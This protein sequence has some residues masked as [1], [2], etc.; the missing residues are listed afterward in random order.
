MHL[1]RLKTQLLN[2]NYHSNFEEVEISL[3]KCSVKIWSSKYWDDKQ[4]Q[5]LSNELYSNELYQCCN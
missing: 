4:V 5:V 3:I 2:E 1:S